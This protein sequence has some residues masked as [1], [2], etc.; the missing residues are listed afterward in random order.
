MV[1][2][3]RPVPAN[4]KRVEVMPGPQAE[5]VLS[6]ALY[7]GYIA[8]RRGGKTSASVIKMMLYMQQ[9]PGAYFMFTVPTLG[10]VDRILL[11]KMREFFG[12]FY[13]QIWGWLEKKSQIV[14]PEYRG[15]DGE[16]GIAFVRPASEPDSLRGPTLAAAAMDEIGTEDQQAAFQILQPA[17]L[18]GQPGFPHQ[19]WVTTTPRVE[20]KWVKQRWD[21]H[22][23]PENGEPLPAEDYPIFRAR[24]V[25][26]FHLEQKAIQSLVA[27][28]GTGRM[29]RQELEGEFLSLEGI[30]LPM[31]DA[32]K[33]LRYP[34]EDAEWVR[35]VF[36]FDIGGTAPTAIVQWK[37]DRL[38]RKWAV[39]EYYKRDA[40]EYDWVRWLA[41]H[42]A[43]RVMCDPAISER[44]RTYWSRRHG[45]QFAH[46]RDKTHE[47]RLTVWRT[48]LIHEGREPTIFI[49]PDCSNLWDE[50]INLRHKRKGEDDYVEQWASGVADHGFDAGAYGLMEFEGAGVQGRP[51][52]MNILWR[53]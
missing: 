14:F 47:S 8:G 32:E 10:D 30:A 52:A 46:A 44:M 28:H 43:K 23:N 4:A 13:G 21:E 20:R 6:K 16:G 35:T 1:V 51:K 36:G 40:D 7:P 18:G 26:N 42:D 31:L 29:G 17:V 2:E 9:N 48:G 53:R 12:A 37:I 19:I 15:V 25:D 49:S 50:L 27:E 45:I 41:D 11:P 34:P 38:N 24:T 3:S 22:I 33:H 39:A 5:F